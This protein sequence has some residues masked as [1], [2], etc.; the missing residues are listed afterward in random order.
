MK[1]KFIVTT[2]CLALSGVLSGQAQTIE[3]GSQ[4]TTKNSMVSGKPYL[5]YYVG[6]NGCY[7]KAL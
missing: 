7:V 1:H 5:L 4:V 3:K 2:L 6:N